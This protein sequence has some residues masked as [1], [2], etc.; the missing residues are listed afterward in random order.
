M[1]RRRRRDMTIARRRVL[2]LAAGALMAPRT[3]LRAGL[4]EP[5]SEDRRAG[6]RGW[7]QRHLDAP[8]RAEAVGEPQAEFLRGEY[9]RRRRQYRNGAGRACG[10]RWLHDD[11][12]R[13][14]V[15]DQPD[16]QSE[17]AVRSGE[18]F[19]AGDADV[20]DAD[21]GGRARVAR[22][23]QPQGADRAAQGQSRQ[24][25]LFVGRHR[26]ARPPRRRIVQGRRRRGHHPRAVLGRRSGDELDDRRTH[27]DQLPGAVHGRAQHHGRQDS[28]ARGVQSEAL[29]DAA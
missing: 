4:S 3:A 13:A 8:D 27:A 14:V 6:R 20:R 24:V 26:H 19:R 22:G 10:A 11:V 28:R 1:G 15:R 23:R 17:D 16:A 29:A 5:R 7:R 21:A 9:S 2:T 12:R 25:Q 18:G